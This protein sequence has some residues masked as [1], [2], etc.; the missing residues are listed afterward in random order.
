MERRFGLQAEKWEMMFELF[1]LL[2]KEKGKCV[3]RQ[4]LERGEGIC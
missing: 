3:V 1:L 4:A 2:G